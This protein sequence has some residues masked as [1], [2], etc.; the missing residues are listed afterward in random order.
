MHNLR[1]RC[2]VSSTVLTSIWLLILRFQIPLLWISPA[3][4]WTLAI[5]TVLLCLMLESRLADQTTPEVT[6]KY[7]PELLRAI[8]R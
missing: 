8:P 1:A 2:L 6:A 5:G 7:A 4:S 3:I